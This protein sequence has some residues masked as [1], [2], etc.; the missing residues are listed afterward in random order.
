MSIQGGIV[1]AL[2]AMAAVYLA[3]RVIRGLSAKGR[4]PGCGGCSASGDCQR[5]VPSPRL[6]QTILLD[7]GRRR[8][9]RKGDER[10]LIRPPWDS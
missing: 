9:G 7:P 6:T 1:F 2:V 8:A 10:G 4:H 5:V 3:R